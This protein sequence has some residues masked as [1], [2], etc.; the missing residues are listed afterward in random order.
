MSETFQGRKLE[1]LKS[2]NNFSASCNLI[3]QYDPL[4]P[5]IKTVIKKYLPVL[6]SLQML[7]IIPEN[8]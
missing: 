1:G 7:Q 3:T 4:L 6:H 5:N 2:N 8:T